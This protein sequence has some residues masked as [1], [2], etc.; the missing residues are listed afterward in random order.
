MKEHWCFISL[1]IPFQL[2]LYKVVPNEYFTR[3]DVPV[4]INR[5]NRLL[6]IKFIEKRT[7][8]F[9]SEKKTQRYYR[10]EFI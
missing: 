9:M 3:K 6:I 10:S 5:L 2:F 1:H 7:C 4:S 8:Y